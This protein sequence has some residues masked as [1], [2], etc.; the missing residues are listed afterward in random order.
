MRRV[1]LTVLAAFALVWLVL[2]AF[3]YWDLTKNSEVDGFQRNRGEILL[4]MM[5][6]IDDA[7]QARFAISLYSDLIQESYRRT[8]EPNLF[9]VQL[10]DR[11][12]H[13][14]YISPNAG[15]A[16]LHGDPG[17]LIDIPWHGGLL[18]VYQGDTPRWT[19]L[20]GE[21][22]KEKARTLSR[23]SGEMAIYILIACP[24][25]LVPVWFARVFTADSW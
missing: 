22:Q 16:Y 4:T 17:Q 6:K 23:I 13:R 11:Q 7:E 15:G 1:S 21:Q 2:L 10:N 3:L 24:L 14:L 20:V 19:V 9:F 8:G 25:V 18:H 5:A 12:G